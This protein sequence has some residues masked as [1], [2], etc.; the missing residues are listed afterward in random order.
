MESKN[1]TIQDVAKR[2]N[3]S[4]ATVSRVINNSSLVR[5]ATRSK[6]L[7]VIETLGYSPNFLGRDLRRDQTMRILLLT[8][9]LIWPIMLDL[10]RGIDDAAQRHGYSVIAAP[11]TNSKKKEQEL[12]AMLKNRFVDGLIVIG[13]T[14]SPQE[15]DDLGKQYSLV[16]CSEWKE[17][18][19][20]S[21][22]SIDDKKAGYDAI[23]YLIKS[24]HKRIAMI[25]SKNSG[26]ALLR[27]QGY[28][29]AIAKA[30]LKFDESLVKFGDFTYEDGL[31]LTKDLLKLEDKPT[32]IF[33]IN[34]VVAVGCVNALKKNGIRV[35][36]EVAVVGFDDTKEAL[37]SIPEITTIAQPKY[38][39]GY[40]TFELL[41][42]QMNQEGSNYQNITLE[43]NLILRGST[44]NIDIKE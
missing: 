7:E 12:I 31:C 30:G 39:L 14:L 24:G 18:K 8:P 34:D 43:H 17:T 33:C 9:S 40:R 36:D 27:L 38:E 19:Y 10:F 6:V 2:A 42:N 4:V 29:E 23:S 11:T 26:S 32:A 37:M 1:L 16:Q 20:T 25:G 5:E 41:I 21:I 35:P 13:S 28:Q 15:L 22:V 3:V 44:V